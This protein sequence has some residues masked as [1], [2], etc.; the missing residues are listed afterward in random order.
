MEI[1][2]NL[3]LTEGQKQAYKLLHDKDVKYMVLVWSRQSGKSVFA[4]IAC[5]EALCNP[6]KFSAYITPQYKHGEK[7]YE[8]L[9]K[10]LEPTGLIKRK[11]GQ[12]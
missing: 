4:E 1:K 7:V 6:N 12:K 11:N 5:I 3:E 9:V 2:F 8:E 10:Y